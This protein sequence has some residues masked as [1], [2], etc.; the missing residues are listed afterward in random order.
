MKLVAVH[1]VLV[2]A[3]AV[4]IDAP[5]VFPFL[6]SLAVPK[7][8]LLAGC[9][10]PELPANFLGLGD[11]KNQVVST[12]PRLF[13]VGDRLRKV[14]DR[15][16]MQAAYFGLYR[17][18]SEPGH[19]RK[20]LGIFGWAFRSETAAKDAHTKLSRRQPVQLERRVPVPTLASLLR[21]CS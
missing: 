10:V 7:D 11:F 20:D 12:D 4:P 19:G 16:T 9:Q 15:T 5:Q 21:G 6:T 17:E 13:I 18:P 14:L 1:C 2:L 8:R 3:T